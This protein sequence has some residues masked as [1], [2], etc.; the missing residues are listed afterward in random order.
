MKKMMVAILIT[1]LLSLTFMSV[2]STHNTESNPILSIKARFV[3]EDDGITAV[4]QVILPILVVV[5]GALAITAI[6]TMIN[7]RKGIKLPAGAPRSYPF[8][9][10]IC[11]QCKRPFGFQAFSLHIIVGKITP[12]PHCGRWSIVRRASLRDLHAAEQAELVTEKGKIA[13]ASKEEKMRE[14]LDDSRYQNL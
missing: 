13:E 10:G 6:P 4:L 5:L 14:A 1:I 12:C 3:S 11:P 7:V 9:G 2:G 8:G